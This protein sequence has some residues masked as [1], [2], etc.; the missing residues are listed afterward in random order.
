MVALFS[1]WGMDVSLKERE[2][3]SHLLL[4]A[5]QQAA[6]AAAAVVNVT[7]VSV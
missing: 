3:S 7:H 6:A 5:H 1:Q 2:K 4:E